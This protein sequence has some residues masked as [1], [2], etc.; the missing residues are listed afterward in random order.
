[1]LINETIIKVY[2]YF[3]KYNRV[4]AQSSLGGLAI[5]LAM[6]AITLCWL[7]W[8]VFVRLLAYLAQY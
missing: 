8:L 4:L 1:M 2:K 7:G 5:Q 3:Y 6:Q